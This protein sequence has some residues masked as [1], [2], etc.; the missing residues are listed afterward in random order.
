MNVGISDMNHDGHP[1][2]YISNMA[3]LVKDD[4][5]I[6]PDVNTPMHLDLRAMS[7]MLIK[8]SDVLYMSRLDGKQL[9]AYEPSKDIER[10][11]TS[12]GWA[13]DAEFLDFD[14]DGDD[15]LYLV[16][17]TNDYHAYAAIYQ[18]RQ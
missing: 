9:T 8:E 14:C 16:N 6:F 13:W 18:L 3:S 17:G 7:G 2:I 10:G 12:T 5:Y 11:A 4:K 15:D 1:D